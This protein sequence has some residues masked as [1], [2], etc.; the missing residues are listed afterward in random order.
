MTRASARVQYRLTTAGKVVLAIGLTAIFILGVSLGSNL[1]AGGDQPPGEQTPVVAN[2]DGDQEQSTPSENGE[3]NSQ[4]GQNGDE[5]ENNTEN[6]LEQR[7]TVNIVPPSLSYDESKLAG[8]SNE[9]IGWGFGNNVDETNRPVGSLNAQNTYGQYDADFIAPQTKNVY[10]TIDEGY[11]NGYTAQI[12]DVLKEKNCPAVF[13]VTL[14]YVKSNPDLV[15]RM[16]DEGHVIGNHS[17]THPSQGLPSQTIA[18]QVNEIKELHQYMLD[19]FGYEMYLFRYPSGIYSEQSLA[20]VQQLGY[21]S[22]FWS[23]AYA[24]WDTENQP[25]PTASLQKLNQKMHEG[26]IYLLHAVSS[27][28]TQ[29]MGQFIDDTRNAGYTFAVYPQ[30]FTQAD[31]AEDAASV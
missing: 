10:L 15:Q 2:N 6:N 25:D 13:F 9:A 21:R 7:E 31:T 24:D 29:I 27:T 23:Y 16:I 8:L 14:S 26:A 5:T 1:F 30:S 22:V 4:E 20:L 28:N 12:L 17:V 18:E 11:E 3:N 19:N